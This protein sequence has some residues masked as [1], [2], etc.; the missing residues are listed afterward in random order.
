MKK[1]KI[2]C[3][4][5]PASESKEVFKSLVENGL[6]IA[7]LNFSHGTHDEHRAR[8]TMIKSIRSELTTPVAIM[9]DTKGPEIRTGT[10]KEKRYFLEKSQKFTLTTRDIIGDNTI[11]SISY[12]ELPKEVKIG[13]SILIDDGLIEMKVLEVKDSTEII[14]EVQNEGEIKN[15]KG[16]NIPGVN[17]SLPSLTEKDIEDI[18]FGIENG[19]DFIAAS[20]IR[21]ATDVL[22]I[23]RVLEENDGEDIH[24]ISKIENSEGVENIDDIIK[25]SDGIM[26]ARG[27]L[28]VEIPIEKIPL[29]QKE[30]TRRCNLAGKPVVTATQMLDSM[31]RN[32]RPTRAESTDIA[33]AIID[34]SDAIMLSGETA[35]GEYPIQAVKIMYNIAIEVEKSLDFSEMLVQ[36]ARQLDKDVTFAVSH[37]TATTALDL[38]ARAIITATSSGFTARMIS[39]LRPKATIVAACTKNHV[40]R[41]LSIFWGVETIYLGS[42]STI[43]EIFDKSL[44]QARE[45]NYVKNGD[46]IVFTAGVPVG[47]S[48]ATNL[49]RVH[50]VGEILLKATGIGK[51]VITGKAVVVEKYT[52]A[53]SLIN[54]GDI[55]V[56]KTTD[57]EIM[58]AIEKSSAMIVEEGGYTSHAA[59]VGLNLNIPTIVGAK[60]ACD[61]IKDGQVITIDSDKGVVYSGNM[62]SL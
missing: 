30:I 27:D 52:D 6:N 2:I 13:S 50:L 24:I 49:M 48:G 54:E 58:K 60:D 55:L 53:N 17:L 22:N 10:L 15:Y 43:E 36:R 44:E 11:T 18:K 61:I 16:V 7:R 26:I 31:I 37:A 38:H 57:R 28:G 39:R 12:K 62:R 23:R 5:G 14:C 9:M 19:V 35:A 1:T 8:I 56:C 41:K 20:F 45:L 51:K 46:M 33:N 59:I 3:T 21:T 25:V 34:G 32:P 47:V 40:R 4:I 29:V 42:H